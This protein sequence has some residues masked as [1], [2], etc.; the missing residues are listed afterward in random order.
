M[1][2]GM[3]FIAAIAVY[4]VAFEVA[5]TLANMLA[6]AGI[7]VIA[8]PFVG[9]ML[10]ACVLPPFILVLLC[11]VAVKR[12]ATDMVAFVI[13][14]LLPLIVFRWMTG[15][16]N[17]IDLPVLASGAVAS[18]LSVRLARRLGVPAYLRSAWTRS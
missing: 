1:E 6:G 16:K 18:L 10:L 13:G 5:F 9:V 15:T 12:G 7:G 8:V 3:R 11:S 17:W 2:V 14:A 4:V